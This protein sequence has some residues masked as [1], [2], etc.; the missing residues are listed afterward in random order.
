MG[1][2]LYIPS[3][4]APGDLQDAFENLS[5]QLSDV[6]QKGYLLEASDIGKRKK[7]H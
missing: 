4:T 5:Y 3:E 1:S 2:T 6:M 7:Q